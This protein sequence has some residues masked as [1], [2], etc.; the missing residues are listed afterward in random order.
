MRGKIS[1]RI[2][3]V[4]IVVTVLFITRAGVAVFADS[5][6]RAPSSCYQ[7][8]SGSR[9]GGGF[10][11]SCLYGSNLS[12]EQ[13]VKIS[14]EREKFIKSTSDIRNSIYQKR[15]EIDD[16]ISKENPD[17]SRLNSLQ[18]ELSELMGKFDKKHIEFVLAM[19][20]IAPGYGSSPRNGSKGNNLPS[21]CGQ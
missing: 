16:T 6:L 5:G 10:G 17:A 12:D 9:T 13:I 3:I 8:C 7:G 18:K 15:K 20:E 19:K 1:I 4:V 21:C 2:Q 14:R 11:A